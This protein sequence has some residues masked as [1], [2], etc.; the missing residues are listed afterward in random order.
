MNEFKLNKDEVDIP[1]LKEQI[2]FLIQLER[3]KKV[4][5]FLPAIYGCIAVLILVCNLTEVYITTG[6][7]FRKLMSYKQDLFV[8]ES[9]KILNPE[10]SELLEGII[11]VLDSIQDKAEKSMG[12]I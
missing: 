4:E 8:I 2:A 10:Q 7:D 1:L 11:N 9:Y 12:E 5:D 3:E 6:T